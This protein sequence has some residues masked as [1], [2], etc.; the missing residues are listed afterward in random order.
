MV[1]WMIAHR[2]DSGPPSNLMKY[3]KLKFLLF[4]LLAAKA[5]GVSERVVFYIAP[6]PKPPHVAPIPKLMKALV[7]VESKGKRYAVGDHGK[8][9]GV[10]Q[11]HETMV[12]EYSRISGRYLN[13]SDMFNPM[14]AE[15]VADVVL[16]FYAQHILT[17]TGRPATLKELAFIWNGGGE[18]WRRA[19]SPIGDSKQRRLE[20][21]WSKVSKNLDA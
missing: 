3:R 8:A 2:F 18:A 9:F 19:A 1:H 15:M 10:L 5:F 21:Y 16:R 17:L 12:E 11:V 6:A 7:K 13:H 14:K 4:M 20:A